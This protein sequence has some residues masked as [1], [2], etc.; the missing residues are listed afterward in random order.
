MLKLAKNVN[1]VAAAT[2]KEAATKNALKLQHRR[3]FSRALEK[4]RGKKGNHLLL[5]LHII[6]VAVVACGNLI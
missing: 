5:L 6:D 4:G 2:K 1:C 3:Q